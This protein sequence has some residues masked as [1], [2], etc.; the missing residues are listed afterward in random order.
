MMNNMEKFVSLF[1]NLRSRLPVA[2]DFDEV[3]TMLSSGQ[4]IDATSNYRRVVVLLDDAVAKGN[5]DEVQ[6]LKNELSRMKAQMPAFIGWVLL[7]GGRTIDNIT[8]Y[9][10]YIMV[11]L[12]HLS[13]IM[14]DE[15][16]KLV[17]AD[18]HTLLAYTTVSGRGIRVVCRMKGAVT[19]D[20]FNLAW[21]TANDYY[22][23]LCGCAF[24]RQCSNPTRM[25]VICHDANVVYR[26][27]AEPLEIVVS[28]TKQS[29]R[30]AINVDV[31]VVG[32]KVR[33]K[34]DSEGLCYGPG[35]HNEYVSRLIYLLNR[36]GVNEADALWWTLNEFADYN[37]SNG[38][39]L[40]AM[41]RSVY[42][43]HRDEHA[44]KKI[45][46]GKQ[47]GNSRDA[48]M[49]VEK[50]INDHYLL[51]MNIVSNAAEWVRKGKNGRPESQFS[52]LDDMFENSLWCELQRE[53]INISL[54]S[55]VTLLKSDFVP[56][57]HPMTDYLDSLPCWDGSTD[58]IGNL[59]KMV[60]CRNVSP[61]KFDHYVRRWFVAMV[62]SAVDDNVINH[63]ILVLLGRQGTFK[64]SFINNILP[65]C[66]RAYYSVKTNSHR[67]D[68]DDSFALAEN[69]LINFEEIDSMQR[70]ELN[71]LKA[72][73]T[74]TYIKDRPAYGRRKVRLPH[75][76]SFCATGNN[77]QFLTD[78]TGNRR[79]LVFEVDYI[80]NPWTADINY[81]GIYAQAKALIEKGYRYWFDSDEID[82]I[83]RHNRDFETPDPAKEMVMTHFRRPEPYEPCLFLTS[84]QIATRFAAQLNVS[85]MAV[86]KVLREMNFEQKRSKSGRF[87]KVAEIQPVDIGKQIPGN[88]PE[89]SLL[90]F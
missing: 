15:A 65:H 79:W 70:A 49:A 68:K 71:Q 45:N 55:L 1:K 35:H 82:D 3:V 58:H 39:M 11:D 59:L 75:R 34:L 17:V 7:D 27:D 76:A 86:G 54:Q 61:Q 22:A 78:N 60:H 28:K 32:A 20:N 85:P 36:Y 43:N 23:Q 37:V 62:A 4:L 33:K 88:T 21:N 67:L 31:K 38:N 48:M 81:E 52:E 6:R 14:Y 69:F 41:V 2:S 12:D 89:E 90:P 57:F 64:S 51:R 13:A 5:D 46:K 83:N 24:D 19:K 47:A 56:L 30:P 53:D 26:P 16:L 8:G 72:L 44:T 50:F 10:G 84:S 42:E 66:L 77:L 40:P 74:V 63:E 18:C 80:D 9:T 29:K 73:T 87:W 25:S